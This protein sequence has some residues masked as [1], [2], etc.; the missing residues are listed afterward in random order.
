MRPINLLAFTL[1]AALLTSCCGDL[2]PAP[3]PGQVITEPAAEQGIPKLGLFALKASN[4]MYVS[5]TMTPDSSGK[6]ILRADR[7]TVG[8]NEVFTAGYDDA[9]RLGIQAPNGKYVAA[10]REMG[11]VLTADREYVGEWESFEVVTQENGLFALKNSN[12]KFVGAHHEWTDAKAS[13]L[14]AD[15]DAANDWE[16]FAIVKD[17]SIGQ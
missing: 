9:G 4:G 11:G 15:R 16:R 1:I 5:C 2:P 7:P 6:I 8:P 10:D 13:M 3:D 17:P 12:G 14:I